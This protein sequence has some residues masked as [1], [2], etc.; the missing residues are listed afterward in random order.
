VS[1]QFDRIVPIDVP[2]ARAEI[3][4]SIS[5]YRRL[6]QLADIVEK[7]LTELPPGKT[8]NA[9]VAQRLHNKL[10][11]HPELRAHSVQYTPDK[12]VTGVPGFILKISMYDMDHVTSAAGYTSFHVRAMNSTEGSGWDVPWAMMG[13]RFWGKSADHLDSLLTVFPH[14][15]R[16][17]NEHLAELRALAKLAEREDMVGPVFPLSDYFH[18]YQ[19]TPP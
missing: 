2:K 19:L 10:V 18:Y 4:K 6:Q 15:A 3:L 12:S 14:R 13:H 8:V 7:F 16:K 5:E 1:Y 9:R 11:E 17:F